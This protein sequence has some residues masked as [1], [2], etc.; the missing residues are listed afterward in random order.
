[1]CIYS[2]ILFRFICYCKYTD[3]AANR[4][5]KKGGKITQKENDRNIVGG[6]RGFSLVELIIVIAIVA[7]LVGVMASQLIK[8]IEKANVSADVQLCDTI[9]TAMVIAMADPVVL[10]DPGSKGI[11]GWYTTG[12]NGGFAY[13]AKTFYMDNSEF[14][15]QV[16]EICGFDPG[17]AAEM[18]GRFRSQPAKTNGRLGAL[19]MPNGEFHIYINHSD[20]TGRKQDY[21]FGTPDKVIMSPQW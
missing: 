12:P 13:W 3:G 8:Y 20:N 4:I 7:I 2:N 21:I 16:I 6:N 19:V 1:M 5:L 14:S 11:I 15:R 18:S 10:T 9:H 17:D